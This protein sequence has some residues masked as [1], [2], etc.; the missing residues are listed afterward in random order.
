MPPGKAAKLTDEQI[1]LIARWIDAGALSDGDPQPDRHAA[2]R[3]RRTG[4]FGRR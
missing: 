1:R 3:A 4:R 2:I